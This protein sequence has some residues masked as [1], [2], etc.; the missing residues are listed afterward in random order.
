M[1]ARAAARRPTRS[2]AGAARG[3]ALQWQRRTRA[4]WQARS[5]ARAQSAPRAR[6]TMRKGC[7]PHA[8]RNYALENAMEAS[9][10]PLVELLEK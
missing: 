6:P 2:R 1:H 10:L 3:S 5:R 7:G 4:S 9:N 8:C